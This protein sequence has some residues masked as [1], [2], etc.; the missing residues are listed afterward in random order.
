MYSSVN[1]ALIFD[2]LT[3]TFFQ[4]LFNSFSTF[5]KSDPCL[6]ANN[7]LLIN[8]RKSRNSCDFSQFFPF[9]F[10]ISLHFYS[11]RKDFLSL[12]QEVHILFLMISLIILF[13]FCMFFY[14]STQYFSTQNFLFVLL[15]ESLRFVSWT[16]PSYLFTLKTFSSWLRLSPMY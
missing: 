8:L 11:H 2:G 3:I 9:H 7:N 1:S 10:E 6:Y 5:Q 13:F 12:F 16:Y 4:N 15:F 14:S